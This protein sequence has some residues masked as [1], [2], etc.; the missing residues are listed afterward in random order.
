MPCAYHVHSGRD[1]GVRQ[2]L[3]GGADVGV[4]DSP[5]KVAGVDILP[6][7][8]VCG[9]VEDLDFLVLLECRCTG[10]NVIRETWRNVGL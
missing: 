7:P 3:L 5:A 4:G 9:R 2:E 6:D 10:R 8:K 1:A